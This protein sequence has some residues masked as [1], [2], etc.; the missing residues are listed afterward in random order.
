MVFMVMRICLVGKKDG[1]VL[2][3][4]FFGFFKIIK[5]FGWEK[6]DF[7]EYNW[8]IFKK[9]MFVKNNLWFLY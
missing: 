3:F 5:K 9:N 6:F 2:D 4:F 1:N 8:M 7:N